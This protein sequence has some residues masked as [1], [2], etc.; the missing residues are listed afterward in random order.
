MTY[1]IKHT[2]A[3]SYLISDQC[4]YSKNSEEDC[5]VIK[6]KPFTRNTPQVFSTYRKDAREFESLNLAK[7][8]L[9]I[10]RRREDN[11]HCKIFFVRLSL[12]GLVRKFLQALDRKQDL[13][14]L[15][16]DMHVSVYTRNKAQKAL[17]EAENTY[18]MLHSQ[19]QEAVDY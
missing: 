2:E 17:I 16:K 19:L 15:H 1:V 5:I 10:L 7:R 18:C 8:A 3:N 11:Q 14:K 9:K 4:L 6:D 13:E 12:R